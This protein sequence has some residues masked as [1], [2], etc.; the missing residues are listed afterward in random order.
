MLLRV[1]K[2]TKNKTLSEPAPV[3]LR[4]VILLMEEPP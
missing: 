4:G 2:K 1:K 3:E